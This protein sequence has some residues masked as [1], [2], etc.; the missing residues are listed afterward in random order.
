M[1]FVNVGTDQY[2]N[3]QHMWEH[4]SINTG[5]GLLPKSNWPGTW[6]AKAVRWTPDPPL[7]RPSYGKKERAGEKKKTVSCHYLHWTEFMPPN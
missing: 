5:I 2:K 7:L 1:D 3:C 6:S 4:A